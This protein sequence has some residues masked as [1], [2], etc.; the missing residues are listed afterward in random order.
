M[1]YQANIPQAA[2]EIQQSQSDLLA[3]FQQINTMLNVNHGALNGVIE[4]KH[5]FCSFPV[6]AAAP[7]VIAGEV[8]MYSRTSTLTTNPELAIK[9]PAGSITEFTAARLSATN[10][11]SYMP[12]GLLL[13]WGA[14]AAGV[15]ATTV[16]YPVGVTYPVFANVFCA[17]LTPNGISALTNAAVITT[18]TTTNMTVQSTAAITLYYVVL[19]N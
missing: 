13:K 4:G 18:L 9:T 1:A 15:G 16:T 5:K 11:W 3:N 12:S 6:Q 10:G 8:G 14:F 7:A 19:G 17:F 2:D